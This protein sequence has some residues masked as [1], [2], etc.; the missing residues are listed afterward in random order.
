[1]PSPPATMTVLRDKILQTICHALRNRHVVDFV[2]ASVRTGYLEFF[3][4]QIEQVNR[5][6]DEAFDR[7]A[8]S[9]R[10]A[11]DPKKLVEVTSLLLDNSFRKGDSS[12]WFNRGYHHYKTQTKPEANSQRCAESCSSS[13]AISGSLHR[14][15]EVLGEG[16]HVRL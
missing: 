7:L 14:Q 4:T 16:G 3:R 8:Q 15:V 11:V 6:L 9:Q 5:M 12:C 10:D 1:M 2:H 13:R